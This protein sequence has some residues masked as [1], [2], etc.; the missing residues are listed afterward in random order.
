MSRLVVDQLQGRTSGSN[1]ITIPTGHK[2]NAVD[3]GAISAPGSIVQHSYQY[4]TNIVSS[5]STSYADIGGNGTMSFTPKFSTSL[6][7]IHFHVAI[8]GKGAF[9]L[10]RNGTSLADPSSGYVF[11]TP[12]TQSDWNSS[13]HR[14]ISSIYWLDTPNTTSAIEYKLQIRAYTATAAQ[15]IGINELFDGINFTFLEIMEIAQ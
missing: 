5:S 10:M 3:A 7:R 9:R 8:S 14:R 6:I 2:I 15:S 13:S 1:T 12:T 4:I 11:F